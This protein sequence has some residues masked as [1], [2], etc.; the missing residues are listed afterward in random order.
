MMDYFIFIADT[1]ARS[2]RGQASL[3]IRE[4]ATGSVDSGAIKRTA[5]GRAA[6]SG[7]QA[8]GRL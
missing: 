4:T 5:T 1:T 6:A 3:D 2:A 7:A 8:L